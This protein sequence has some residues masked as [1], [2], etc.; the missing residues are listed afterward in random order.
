VKKPYVFPSPTIYLTSVN[1]IT[2]RYTFVSTRN[3]HNQTHNYTICG[4]VGSM[5]FSCFSYSPNTSPT[6][7]EKSV[8]N[9][10]H[11]ILLNFFL[12]NYQIPIT[13]YEW[14]GG[15][16]GGE[17]HNLL[18]G[19]SCYTPFNFQKSIEPLHYVVPMGITMITTRLKAT[20]PYV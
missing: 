14:N 3:Y 8:S 12:T 6:H 13:N 18:E 4:G 19:V 15:R 10:P 11:K 9:L 1:I 20:E 7:Q 5:S 17:F 16:S 2:F